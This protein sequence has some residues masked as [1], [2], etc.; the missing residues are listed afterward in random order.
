MKILIKTILYLILIS[1][2]LHDDL[3]PTITTIE[4]LFCGKEN[5]TDCAPNFQDLT[6]QICEG[7]LACCWEAINPNPLDIPWCYKGI[8]LPTTILTTILTTLPAEILTTIPTTIM[9]KIPT[10]IMT[11][12][13]TTISTTIT[14]TFPITLT[15]YINK[16]QELECSYIFQN[17]SY[18]FLSFQQI[19][20]LSYLFQLF[21]LLVILLIIKYLKI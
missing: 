16:T 11:T 12:I 4:G 6:Q 20:L 2:Y 18:S 19:V 17:F 14:T 1:R 5:K 15:T 9:T 13:P 8:L 7:Q 21:F 3:E 10:S